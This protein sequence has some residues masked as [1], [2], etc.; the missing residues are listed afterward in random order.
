MHVVWV[1]AAAVLS[2]VDY[3]R[4]ATMLAAKHRFPDRRVESLRVDEVEVEGD[5]AYVKAS[6]RLSRSCEEVVFSVHVE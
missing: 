6:A 4:V 5:T 1:E 2:F 3:A